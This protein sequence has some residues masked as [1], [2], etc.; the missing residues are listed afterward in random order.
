MTADFSWITT[1]LLTRL[2]L[3]A[4]AVVVV[5]ALIGRRVRGW[6]L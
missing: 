2:A 3:Y 5:L 6:G 4:A 1:D